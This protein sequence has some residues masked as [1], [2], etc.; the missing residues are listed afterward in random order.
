MTQDTPPEHATAAPSPSEAALPATALPATALPETAHATPHATAEGTPPADRARLR[1]L[2]TTDLHMQILPYDY[3]R[4]QPMAGC[5]LALAAG[6]IAEERAGC[7]NTLL[8]DNGDLLHGNPSADYLAHRWQA[9]VHS[10][11]PMI[12][13]MNM[14]GYDAATLGNHDFDHGTGFT[15]E[16][17][18]GARFPVVLTNARLA[19]DVPE[20]IRPSAILDRTV[21]TESGAAA[22]LRIGILGFMPRQTPLWGHDLQETLTTEDALPAAAREAAALRAAGADLVIALYHGGIARLAAARAPENDALA[23]AAVPGIDALVAGHTHDVFPGPAFAETPGVDGATGCIGRVPAVMAGFWGS[24]LGVIDLDLARDAGG[25]WRVAQGRARARPVPSTLPREGAA[26]VPGCAVTVALPA[27]TLLAHAETLDYLRRPIGETR[28]RLDSYLAVIGRDA[29]QQMIG[30]AMTDHLA[31][32]LPR[33]ARDLPLIAAVTPFRAGGH[34]GPQNYTDLGPGPLTQRS[35]AA[36][37]PY[38]NRLCAVQVPGAM[39]R[40]WLERSVTA[41]ATLREGG[42]DQPLMAPHWASYN[43]DAMTGLDWTLDLAQPPAFDPG[44]AAL[45]GPGRVRDLRHDGRLVGAED[46]FIVATNS[47]RLSSGGLFA[48]LTAR[49]EALPMRTVLCRDVLGDYIAA[50]PALDIAA[51][52]LWHLAP[53]SGAAAVFDTGP[54]AAAILADIPAL[55]SLGPTA[56]GGL[57]LR[58]RLDLTG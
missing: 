27:P 24:H 33:E 32:H 37:Y 4:D 50:H 3:F 55:E 20:A 9:G 7:P 26:A 29:A 16:A 18:A 45:G 52:P 42:G 54:Q 51:R 58:L 35:L 30:A 41:F 15:M 5:G 6:V 34:G 44:G 57:R 2:C 23:M 46:A 38:P 13:L 17:V 10:T 28:S 48:P 56:E 31:R 53:V 40:E 25:A 49:L 12:A 36:L 8:L 43:L 47:Y 19:G 1:L 11:H 22:A 21:T 39:L 14:L